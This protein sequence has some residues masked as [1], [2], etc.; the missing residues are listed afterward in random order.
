MT[1]FLDPNKITGLIALCMSTLTAYAYWPYVWRAVSIPVGRM[2]AGV[3]AFVSIMAC[4]LLWW[5]VI[6]TN[7]SE[8][9][10]VYVRTADW[11]GITP[12]VWI[13]TSFNTLWIIACYVVL[14]SIYMSIPAQ[15]RPKWHVLTAPFYPDKPRVFRRFFRRARK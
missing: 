13:N 3:F 1:E 4:R 15:E 12:W 10:R 14:S 6:A 9:Q 5:D 7:L 2:A 11:L 8:A